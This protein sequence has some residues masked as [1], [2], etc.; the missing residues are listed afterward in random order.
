MM[1]MLLATDGKPH[2][3]KAVS[4]ALDYA[5]RYDADLFI[6]YVV[7]PKS[8]EDREKTIANGM[9]V[10]EEVKTK[11]LELGL[12][13]TTLLEAGSPHEA[14]LAV[15][16]RI[17]TD[18]IVVGTSGKTAMDRVLIGSVSEFIVRNARSTVIVVR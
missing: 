13:V 12:S 5:K 10:L 9:K 6:V 17:G 11:A 18:A 8:G 14:T 3:E 7:S 1:R 16:E 4:Y 2:S 15:A